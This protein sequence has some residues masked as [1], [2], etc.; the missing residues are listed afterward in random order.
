MLLMC[1][2]KYALFIYITTAHR[3]SID[4]KIQVKAT[5]KNRVHP[6][7]DV[8][9]LLVHY[10]ARSLQYTTLVNKQLSTTQP[11][12][13]GFRQCCSSWGERKRNDLTE[14]RQQSA[15]CM[16]FLSDP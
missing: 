5:A 1:H 6:L 13:K 10:T 4:M 15:T 3:P 12:V 9:S 11:I 2:S 16:A 7:V 8:A 14:S